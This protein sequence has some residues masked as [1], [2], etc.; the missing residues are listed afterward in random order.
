MF[1]LIFF[2][3]KVVQLIISVRTHI[4]VIIKEHREKQK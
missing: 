4:N 1:F 2:E 3:K